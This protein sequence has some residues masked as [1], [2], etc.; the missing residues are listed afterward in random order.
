MSQPLTRRDIEEFTARLL[1]T[2]DELSAAADVLGQIRHLLNT[3]GVRRPAAQATKT[4][5]GKTAARTRKAR[6]RR[7]R[8]S[9]GGVPEKILLS[10]AS[11]K[12]GLAAG[13]IGKIH[14]IDKGA[15]AYALRKLRADGKVRMTGN[16]STALW[17]VAGNSAPTTV[18]AP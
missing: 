4:R 18:A 6:G 15:V 12:A 10:I 2:F 17:H 3:N 1:A 8:A 11:T 5:V 13:E 7:G 9:S 14:G 16:R